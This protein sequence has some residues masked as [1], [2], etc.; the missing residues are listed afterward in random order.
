MLMSERAE[1]NASQGRTYIPRLSCDERMN[2]YS[3]KTY[4]QKN[5]NLS[6]ALKKAFQLMV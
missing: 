3:Y 1:N 4:V 6:P 2:E 5:P